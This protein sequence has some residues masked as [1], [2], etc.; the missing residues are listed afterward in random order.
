MLRPSKQAT[1]MCSGVKEREAPPPRAAKAKAKTPPV[2]SPR[3]V[4]PPPPR[5][6]EPEYAVR[7]SSRPVSALER[8]YGEAIHRYVRLYVSADFSKTVSAWLQVGLPL[9]PAAAARVAR[10]LCFSVGGAT[11]LGKM[12]WVCAASRAWRRWTRTARG[13]P[14]CRWS[15]R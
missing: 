12:T 3:P 13:A 14:W 6:K 5:K 10:P 11:Q 4:T 2:R 9:H 7:L 8:D 15:A 1:C